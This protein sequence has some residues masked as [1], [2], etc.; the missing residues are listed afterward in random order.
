[1]P[2]TVLADWERVGQTGRIE[3]DGL[4]PASGSVVVA[5]GRIDN[6]AELQVTLGLPP[7]TS[8]R[9]LVSRAYERWGVD[10]ADRLRGDFA[11]VVW[12]AVAGVLTAARDPFG[13]APLFYRADG[14]RLWISDAMAPL[15]ATLEVTPVLDDQRVVEFLLTKVKAKDATFFRDIHEVQAGHVLQATPNGLRSRRYWKQPDGPLLP[16][17]RAAEHFEEFRRLFVSAV[18]RRLSSD[19]PVLM[20][21]SGGLDSSAIVGAADLLSRTGALPTPSAVAVGAVH[22]GLACDESVF[23]DAVARHV[24]LPVETWDGTVANDADFVEPRAEEPGLRTLFMGGSLGDVEIARRRGANVILGGLGGD[25]LGM[26]QGLFE[27]QLAAGHWVQALRQ[28]L[29]FPG[30]TR[31]SRMYRVR[32]QLKR[33]LPE[34]VVRP[35]LRARVNVPSWLAPDLHERVRDILLEDR[36]EV[37]PLTGV[38]AEAWRRLNSGQTLRTVSMPVAHGKP[39]GIEYRF[40]FLDRDLLEFALRMPTELWPQSGAYARLHRLP[41]QDLYPPE[42]RSR[43]TK[44]EFTPALIAYLK[45]MS[46]H[47][48]SLAESGAWAS[49]RYVNPELARR[50]CRD[51]TGP[52]KSYSL[53]RRQVRSIVT[54]EAWLRSRQGYSSRR[55]IKETPP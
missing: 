13:V 26:V 3:V 23:I 17:G 29:V 11:I 42:I 6:R 14:R 31:R 49:A 53:S 10:F 16:E 28:L 24:A 48:D 46:K 45:A 50:F 21:L 36:T 34:A 51:V 15:L 47:M 7:A 20:Q 38:R 8:D 44:A 35:L 5:D 32:Q 25:Q 40:P 2:W 55:L 9:E 4:A 27:E 39:L 12:D 43:E 19:S 37:G 30:A 22:P 41:L 1:M 33:S 54:F 52:G 18:R